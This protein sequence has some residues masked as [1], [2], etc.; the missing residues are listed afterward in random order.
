MRLAPYSSKKSLASG[1]GSYCK[2]GESLL[3]KVALGPRGGPWGRVRRAHSSGYPWAVWP[4]DQAQATNHVGECLAVEGSSPTWG[5]GGAPVMEQAVASLLAWRHC[6]TWG[7]VH[8]PHIQGAAVQ[9]AQRAGGCGILGGSRVSQ[10]TA[11]LCHRHF[12]GFSTLV[13]KLHIV[14]RTL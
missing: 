7:G 8:L 5:P 13:V 14:K 9:N 10:G 3:D 2:S 11:F 6:L 4:G 12:C 1:K